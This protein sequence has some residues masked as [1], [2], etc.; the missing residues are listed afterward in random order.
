MEN[1]QTN[2]VL[3]GQGGGGNKFFCEDKKHAQM[4]IGS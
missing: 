2:G 3:R 1:E 4:K